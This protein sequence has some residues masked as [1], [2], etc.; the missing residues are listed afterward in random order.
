MDKAI[1]AAGGKVTGRYQ[2][3]YNGV[4]VRAAGKR[5]SDLAAIKGV[6]AIRPL[7]T[8]SIDNTNAVPY[9]GAPAAWQANGATGEGVTIAVID[10]GIDY[11]HADFGGPGTTAAYDANNPAV[12]ESGSFP[13]AKVIAGYDFAG[14][15]YDADGEAGSHHADS[16]SRPARLRRPRLARSGTAAGQG[17]LADHSTY[18]GPYDSSIYA[19]SGKFTVGPGVAPEA[20]LVALKV[21]GCEGTTSLVVDALEWVASY[22]VSHADGIDVVNMSL[23]SAVR[24]EHRPRRR[25][26]QQPGGHG[27]RRRRFRGQRRRR[28]VRHGR[29]GRVHQ[30]HLGRGA[31]RLP[32]H[33]DGHR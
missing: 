5:L 16:R 15:D 26:H 29:P 10:T 24:L 33:P 27:R 11:T 8:Y 22:N 31:R 23:G 12:I 28:P 2:Y 1:K 25:R 30:G 9:V 18:A 14:N 4:R 17:V 6:V 32:G 19:A 13:T 20:K 7:K 21:F 3:A